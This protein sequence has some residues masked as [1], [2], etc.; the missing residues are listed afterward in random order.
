MTTIAAI[1]GE[2]WAVV[3]ADSQVTE[4]SK[5]YVLPDAFSKMF[6][7]G[8]YLIA[9]AGDFRAVNILTHNFRPPS[10][11]KHTGESLDKFMVSVF[12][13]KLKVCFENNAYGKDNETASDLIV[14]VKGVI[15]EIGSD[16]DCIRDANGL[17]SIGSGSSYALGALHV[18]DTK[19]RTLASAKESVRSALGASCLYDSHTSAP[20][21]IVVQGY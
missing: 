12:V 19:N 6:Q 2:N 21:T 3:G 18:L 11:G 8:P 17:Y 14:V 5:K 9:I 20:I 13:P 16:Y 10:P 7:N 15:Y 4:D 1:Q